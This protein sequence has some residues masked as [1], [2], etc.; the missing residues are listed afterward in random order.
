MG[1]T[2]PSGTGR[3]I[4][5]PQLQPR[6]TALIKGAGYR[7][8]EPIVVGIQQRGA[9]P[10]LRAQGL[11][12]SGEPLTATT[13]IYAASLSKQMTAACA[14]LFAQHGELDMESALSRWLPQ[15]PAWADTVRLRHLVHHAAALPPDSKIDATM[16]SDADRTTPSVLQALAR[17]PALDRQPGTEHVYSNAAYVC[18][19]AAVEQAAGQPLPQFAQRQLFAPLAMVDTCYWRGPD[20]T[21]PGAAV[22]ASRPAVP[23]RRRRVDHRQR[24]AAMEPGTQRRRTRHLDTHADPRMSR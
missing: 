4:S 6:M 23:G 19:A 22:S 9:P 14:A 3:I 7:S 12:S 8:D 18:L 17:F 2:T 11:I 10:I 13:L 21:P 24:S 16:A 5:V 15:L 1:M 20:P